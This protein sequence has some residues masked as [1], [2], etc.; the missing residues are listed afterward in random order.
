MANQ[1][2]KAPTSFAELIALKPLGPQSTITLNAP[3]KIE[4]FES[5]APPH[6]SGDGSHAFGG[7]GFVVHSMS[8]T[9]I[10]AGRAEV[11]YIYTVR[12]LRDG[13]VY[14]TRAVDARQDG[15]IC[16]SGIVS[17]KRAE[18]R[19][20]FGHQPPSAQERYRSILESKRPEEQPVSPS[21]DSETWISQVRSGK[22]AEPEFPGLDVRKVDMTG[23]NDSPEIKRSPE[24]YR[25][26]ALYSL[27]GS[28]DAGAG[29]EKEGLRLRE[30]EAEGEFDNLYACAHMYAS[31]KNSLLLI[32][33]ALGIRE[34]R[35]LASL[36]LTI[37]L[38]LHGEPL[39][40]IDW[41]AVQDECQTAEV[42]KKWFIQ[43][44]STPQSGESRGVHQS[45]L[46]APDGKLLATCYQDG[47][48]R[49][50]GRL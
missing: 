49:V 23:F 29:T 17:F 45:W 40:M 2:S 50:N 33:R 36:T 4:Q 41:D 47:M 1:P 6:C 42:P 39:R 10:L 25:Q 14:C 44:T 38:H 20:A 43:E 21:V 7:H 46:W 16:F 9:F 3:E 12:H 35:A 37:V 22:V 26:L 18:K 15:R 19:D 5:I 30:R 32:P 13:A 8:G 11:P 27:T 28:P 24:K 34:W 48:M 31:D